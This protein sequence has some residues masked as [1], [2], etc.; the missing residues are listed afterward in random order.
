MMYH[1]MYRLNKNPTYHLYSFNESCTQKDVDNLKKNL[2]TWNGQRADIKV[3]CV[4][5]GQRVILASEKLDDKERSL[6]GKS[7]KLK[8]GLC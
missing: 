5:D 1:L 7:W 4:E 2:H 3:I 8:R 6:L